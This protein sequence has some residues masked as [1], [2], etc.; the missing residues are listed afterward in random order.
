MAFIGY[1][2]LTAALSGIIL[3]ANLPTRLTIGAIV[4]TVEFLAETQLKKLEPGQAVAGPQIKA[5][6]LFSAG[7]PLLVMAQASALCSA[8]STRFADKGVRVVGV[9]HEQHGVDQFRPFLPCADAIYLDEEKRFFGPSQRWLP[10]WMGFLRLSTYVNF[11]KAWKA[12]FAGNSEGE[13]RLLGGVYL[14]NGDKM[15]FAHLEKQ[16][17]DEVKMD[18]LVDAVSK[19]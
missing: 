3:Y 2:A 13:G 18:K 12:G 15:L 6:D 5:N 16:W 14:V 11:Y 9:V 19:I 8:A 7:H 10:L 1:G 4:P 17:G